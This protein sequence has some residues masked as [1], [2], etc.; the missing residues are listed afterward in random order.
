[1][2]DEDT[3]RTVPP[4]PPDMQWDAARYESVSYPSPDF[5]DGR[6]AI[7]N[8]HHGPLEH[9]AVI[10]SVRGSVRANHWHPGINVQR[11]LLLSGRYRV[12]SVPLDAQ[13][14][15][16]GE[17]REFVVEEGGLTTTG[18][19]I[20]H[21]YLFEEDSVFLNLNSSGRDPGGYGVHTIPMDVPLFD[22]AGLRPIPL[23]DPVAAHEGR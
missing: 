20:G 3:K 11:M 2:M 9:V 22:P 21:A 10:T 7:T 13:G 4:P 18:P 23:G 17:V 12:R 8:I 1:M 16:I 15:P 14:R 5:E 6:G 19:Y